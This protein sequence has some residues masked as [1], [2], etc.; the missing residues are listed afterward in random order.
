MLFACIYV[1]NF[2]VEAVVRSEPV[3][4]EQPVAVL[5]GTPP[6]V[7]LFA[8]NERACACG[9]EIGMTK[10][11][12]ETCSGLVLRPRSL[13]AEAAAHAALLDCAQSFSPIVEDT[14]ADTVILDIEGLERLFGPPAA[15]ARDLA[16]R[17][18]DLGME[19][20]VAAAAN[21][22]AALH[23][24]RGFYGVTVIPCGKGAERLG[25]LPLPVLLPGLPNKNLADRNHAEARRELLQTLD[26]WGVRTFRALAA[27]PEVAL[28]ERLGQ[29]GVHLQKMAR[30]ETARTLVLAH[31][32]L[33]FEEAVELEYPVALLEPLTFIL[34]RMLE[35]LCARLTVRALATNELR[36]HL[37]LDTSEVDIQEVHIKE[38]HIK[39]L[40]TQQQKSVSPHYQRTLHLPVPMLNAKTFLKL[41]QLE[42][43]SHPP[44]APIRK[45]WLSAEPVRPRVAQ[46]GLF[47]PLTPEAEKLELTLARIA[48]IVGNSRCGSPEM[49]D[50]HR[51]EAFRIVHFA[52][53]APKYDAQ[54]PSSKRQDAVT[55][56]RIFRPP[57]P[58]SVIVHAGA[59]VRLTSALHPVLR[60]EIVWSAGPWRG[61]GDWWSEQGWAREEWDVV[62][63]NESVVALYRMFRDG[64]SG[65]WFIAGSYD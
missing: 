29:P 61:S 18:S 55:A 42:L 22:D 5:H 60:G 35:Q 58:A 21:P 3:L 44:G 27:L 37:E 56:L 20:N 59:P 2:P 17:A 64:K 16:R 31:P 48:S 34:N 65:Q 45:V 9:G 25:E 50:T 39:D 43:Q 41:L 40:H 63:Q 38:L 7:K 53:T 6:L 11:Q 57:L 47:L 23:A 12:A 14:A 32:P 51:P 13:L 4:R 54:S 49:L 46:T 1:P 62:L 19:A 8:L 28:S 30:G 10:L 33:N 24:A 15:I 52:P 26:R 36:L